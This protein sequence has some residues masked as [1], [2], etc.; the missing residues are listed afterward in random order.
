MC[1]VFVYAGLAHP[2]RLHVLAVLLWA[3]NVAQASAGGSCHSAA[4][5]LWLRNFEDEQSYEQYMGH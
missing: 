2:K 5:V 1:C 4:A 3:C